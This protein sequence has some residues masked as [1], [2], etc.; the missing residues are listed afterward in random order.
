MTRLPLLYV[1][2]KNQSSERVISI[3]ADTVKQLVQKHILIQ[4]EEV[5][6]EVDAIPTM[7]EGLN[8]DGARPLTMTFQSLEIDGK[9]NNVL[10]TVGLVDDEGTNKLRAFVCDLQKAVE[11]KGWK[12]AFPPDPNE[13]AN[14]SVGGF[15]PRIPFMELPKTFDDNLSRFKDE[16]TEITEEDVAFLTSDQGGNGISPIFWCQ[17]WDDVFGQNIRMQ[18]VGIYPRTKSDAGEDLSYSMFYL[19]YETIPLP[20]GNAAMLQTEKKFQNYQDTR[21]EEEQEKMYQEGKN[22][23]DAPTSRNDEPDILMTK[24]R[25]RL[26]NIFENSAEDAIIET[27][28]EQEVPEIQNSQSSPTE[29]NVDATEEEEESLDLDLNQPTASPD[30][31]MKE[32]IRTIVESRESTKS[33]IP[34]KKEMPPI[35]DNPVFK[36]Y[37]EGT[38]VP[39]EQRPKATEKKLGPYPGRDHFIGIWRVVTSPTGFPAEESTDETSENLILRVDGTTAGGPILDAETRQKAAGGTWKMIVD[40]DGD[41]RLRIRLVIPPK[42]ERILVMEGVVNRM[43]MS[44]DIPMASKAF[45]I[46]HLEAMAKEANEG[47]LDLMHCGGEVRTVTRD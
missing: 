26:E 43:N 28:V 25:E 33:R 42:K 36:S 8:A 15:R 45:G 46:P 30:D 19:P 44:T 21:L 23:N 2:A 37:K 11:A 4:T 3:L 47:M 38:L 1:Q 7:D 29:E 9:N 18:E 41:V 39:K 35:E 6:E 5:S 13:P 31:W 16:S 10:N 27:I 22:N 32:R 14:D 17:W 20:D 34:V 12:T 24:T 40:E